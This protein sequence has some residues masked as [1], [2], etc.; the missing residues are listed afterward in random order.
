MSILENQSAKSKS[1][2]AVNTRIGTNSGQKVTLK[3]S[4]LRN[5][6]N[7]LKQTNLEAVENT[8][9]TITADSISASGGSDVVKSNLDYVTEHMEK[10]NHCV[11]STDFI[12]SLNDS[13]FKKADKLQNTMNKCMNE[14]FDATGKLLETIQKEA[15]A[16]VSYAKVLD[17]VD[18]DIAR[19]AGDL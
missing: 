16:T 11:N 13:I 8:T 12:T 7:G 9:Q 1:R 2:Q 10:I 15:A 6:Y 19:K 14:Y 18:R 3:A 4:E 17:D 5:K